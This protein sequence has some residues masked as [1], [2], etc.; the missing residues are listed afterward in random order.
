MT[1]APTTARPATSAGT[2]AAD[3]SVIEPAAR[4]PLLL[5]LGSGI[6]WL[7][8]SGVLALITSIQLHSPNFLSHYSF[9]TYGRA[10]AMR[11]SAFVYG[12]AA[13]AG[14]AV[15]LWLLGRLGGAHLR[16]LNWA[17]FGGVAW[18][19]AV[20]AGLIGIAVGDMTSF[21][22]FQLPHYVQPFLAVAY[23][24]IAISGVLAWLDR[25]HDVM[26]A[27]QWYAA[28][29][30][31]LFPWL[32][33]AT[34]LVLLWSPLRGVGQ[35]I[36]A[37]W[38]SQSAWHLWLAP[39]ALAAA[40]YLTPKLSGR[41]LPSYDTAKLGF[42]TLLLLG[43]WAGPRHLIGGPAPAWVVSM[44]IV[45]AVILVMHYVIVAMNLRAIWGIRG[46]SA[47]FIR[48]GLLAY[49]LG[50]VID[51]IV[52]FRGVALETQ[53]T[54]FGPAMQQLSLYGAFSMILFGAI[55]FMVPRLTGHAWVSTG[56]TIGHRV[57]V[58][59]G[60]LVLVLALAVAGWSQGVDLL[61]PKTPISDVLDHI[62][63]PL[64]MV[65]GAQLA[66]L[67]ANILLLVN[68]FSTIS[69]TVVA[70]VTALSPIRP[71]SEASAS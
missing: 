31:F 35:A 10:E 1:N 63:L 45:A 24:A 16:A 44:A 12:W 47:G 64:L 11:E 4:G 48:L 52:S 19:L 7:V 14:L 9:L 40:Y 49:V 5:L 39:I 58:T 54:L 50:G 66:L 6:V 55:Y 57:L 59:I 8:I 27:S 29:A 20:L 43:G 60:V 2:A 62:G 53:F 51:S 37:T 18:N 68:F 26:Y 61:N 28:T 21:A 46:T 34:Q 65:S 30:L 17:F 67:G 42:W 71:A 32:S 36:A 23:V 13:N 22:F 25:R 3:V 33:T 70:D 56:L 41:A 15:T 38:Y 69:A